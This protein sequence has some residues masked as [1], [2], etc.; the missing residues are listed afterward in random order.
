[1]G[2]RLTYKASVKKDLRKLAVTARRAVVRRILILAEE[3]RPTSAT[4]LQGSDDLY[5]IRQGDY[6]IV[7]SINDQIVTIEIIK[8]G[9]RKDVYRQH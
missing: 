8:I 5:R 2:Y 9:H 1:M 7:Y 3:P 6:R 4:K